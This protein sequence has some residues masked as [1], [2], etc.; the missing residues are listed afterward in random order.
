M[1]EHQHDESTT[2][3][4]AACRDDEPDGEADQRP[5]EFV[6]VFV[7]G[8]PSDVTQEQVTE[9]FS[10]IGEVLSV[11]LNRRK[12][13]GECKGFGFVRYGNQLTAEVACR[14]VKEVRLFT[15]V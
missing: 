4:R 6:E 14:D 9:V 2:M 5:A 1:Q 13:T 7:G 15:L 10:K 11:R 8:L 3:I 12:K